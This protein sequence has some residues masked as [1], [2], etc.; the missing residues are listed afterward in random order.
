MLV[1]APD[2]F[3]IIFGTAQEC[4]SAMKITF[5]HSPED[6]YGQN[7]GTKF[8]P[9]WAFY[10]ASFVPKHWDV[11]IVDCR[12]DNIDDCDCADVFGLP[13]AGRAN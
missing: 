12:L 6:I 4:L 8:I 13:Q 7:Y 5:I 1:I 11:Q 10:L 2:M 3:Y 9:Y